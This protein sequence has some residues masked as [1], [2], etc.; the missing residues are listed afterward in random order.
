MTEAGRQLGI[1]L[2]GAPLDPP[3][4]EAAYLEAFG[5]MAEAGVEAFVVGDGPENNSNRHTIARLAEAH[6]WPAIYPYKDETLEG[7]LMSYG[8]DLDDVFRRA[9]EYVARILAGT[10]PGELPIYRPTKFEL[11]IN[12]RA[13]VAIGLKFP[14]ALLVRADKVIE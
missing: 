11:F 10:K 9:A 1:T 12:A 8:T 2:I 7:G 6:K 4:H 14:E 3:V 13:A 5:R